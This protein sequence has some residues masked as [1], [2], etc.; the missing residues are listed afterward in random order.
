MAKKRKK[1]DPSSRDAKRK[2]RKATELNVT[3][4]VAAVRVRQARP[5][6]LVAVYGP[7]TMEALVPASERGR[8][9]R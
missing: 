1:A 5:R 9:K 3:A 6:Y 2:A 7:V 4:S 8:R